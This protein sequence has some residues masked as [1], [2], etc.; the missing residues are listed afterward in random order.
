[1]NIYATFSGAQYYEPTRR[2]VEDAP[3]FGAD[4]VWVMDDVWLE[5]KRPGY[6]EKTRYFREHPGRRGVDWFVFKPFVI[7]DAFRRLQPGDVLLYVD[8][9]TYPIA[10]LGPLFARCRA[11]GGVMLFSAIG[12]VN[13]AWTKRDAFVA[14]GCDEPAYH[15]AQHAVARFILFE[16]CGA[17]PVERFLGEWLGFTASPFV[18]TFDPSVLG[19]PELEG[20]KQNRCEQ[21]VL[22]NLAVKYGVRLYREAC[23]FGADNPL[24][25]DLYPQTFIQDGRHTFDPSGNRDGS[26]FRNVTT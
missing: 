15:D 25:Q 19:L 13:R 16:N 6:W 8:G 20:F 2:T 23:Q 9:D 11:D 5:H 10:P 21:S 14:M 24:D 3:R 12:C 1:V 17:F 26:S 7:L 18:N 4:A 22:T